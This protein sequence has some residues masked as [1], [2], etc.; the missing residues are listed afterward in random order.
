MIRGILFD[1][2]G[3]LLDFDATWR[4]FVEETLHAVAPHDAEL[5][6]KL[7]DLAGLDPTTGRFRA[8]SPA[9]SGATSEVAVLWA[10]H[11]PGRSA[12]D[13]E[14]EIDDRAA[15]A[16]L[17]GPTAAAPDLPGLLDGF[18]ARGMALGVA[19]HDS[20]R[21]ARAHM[22]LLGALEK[23][24][25]IA[26][27]DSGHGLKPGPGMVL[28]FAAAAGIP[29]HQIAMIGD[30]LHDLGAGR[31]AGAGLVVGV[32]TGPADAAELAPHADHVVGSIAE[33]PELL[34]SLALV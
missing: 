12:Q 11:L 7:S 19:T 20:E 22:T 31:A 33:L 21:A 30:S 5:R 27:Y 17:D 28:A 16:V 10:P 34:A 14:A 3:T 9:V 8:G 13:I 4:G 15:S 29:P 25:F 32:L 26:G 2:D 23:F 18:R 24:D 1:K 6:A